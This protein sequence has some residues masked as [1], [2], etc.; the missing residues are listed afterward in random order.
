MANNDDIF[1]KLIG[2]WMEEL[3]DDEWWA[4]YYAWKKAK[5]ARALSDESNS[6]EEE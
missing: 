4:R 5:R 2:S 1:D 3:S 6:Q